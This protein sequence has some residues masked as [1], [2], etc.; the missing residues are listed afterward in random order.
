[1]GKNYG[2]LVK[3]TYNNKYA[4]VTGASGGL[5]REIVTELCH[6]G[7]NLVIIGRNMEK[8][9]YFKNSL[10]TYENQ[11][12]DA[13]QCDITEEKDINRLFKYISNQKIHL[14]LV[15]NN[16]GLEVEGWFK[17]IPYEE[18]INIAKINV[19]GTLNI[20]RRSIDYKAEKLTILTI[21]S[22]AGFFPMP[23]K[24]VYSASKRFLID[25]TRTLSYELKDDN[26]SFT[27]V[28]PAGMPTR[29]D[30][31]QK[32]KSQGFMGNLTTIN[33]NE[34][35]RKSLIKAEKGKLIY[36]PGRFNKFMTTVSMMIPKKTVVRMLGKRWKKTSRSK[37][38]E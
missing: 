36:I 5:G 35:V 22:M 20:I 38:L 37:E 16:A 14:D 3:N 13:I 19:V 8:L 15:V 34:V 18:T 33:F 4:L 24:A 29:I 2:K 6:K 23:M 32:I 12:I 26:V 30:I 27:V 11:R 31:L 7:Y 10:L 28:C 1:M 21:S 25:L 9:E 17:D